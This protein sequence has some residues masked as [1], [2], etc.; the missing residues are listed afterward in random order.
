[1]VAN[2]IR[3]TISLNH[4]I[5][6]INRKVKTTEF[7]IQKTGKPRP[8]K[9]IA[10]LLEGGMTAADTDINNSINREIDTSLSNVFMMISE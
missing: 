3:N 6:N 1:V 7:I 4:L 2:K 10:K 8:D 9:A 5:L